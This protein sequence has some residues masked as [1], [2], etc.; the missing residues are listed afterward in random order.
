MALRDLAETPASGTDIL[1]GDGAREM[2]LALRAEELARWNFIR[3]ADPEVAFANDLMRWRFRI[4]RPV[5][6]WDAARTTRDMKSLVRRLDGID[7]CAPAVPLRLGPERIDVSYYVLQWPG[8]AF[9]LTGGGDRWNDSWRHVAIAPRAHLALTRRI[10][11][12]KKLR[13]RG[14]MPAAGT[15]DGAS[16]GMPCDAWAIHHEVAPDGLLRAWVDPLPPWPAEYLE[17][18]PLSW[19]ELAPPRG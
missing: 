4:G 17:Q 5:L 2:M 9:T 7:P 8:C 1:V 10:L 12:L 3:G 16:A 13:A 6:A 14:A 19:T 11:E 18:A 15:M